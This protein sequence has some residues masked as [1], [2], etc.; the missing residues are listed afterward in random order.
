M[1]GILNLFSEPAR[2]LEATLAALDK[3]EPI[4]LGNPRWSESALDEALRLVPVGCQVLG[5]TAQPRGLAP[6]DWPRAWSA[7]IMI[8]TGGTGGRVK[9]AIHHRSTLA[10]AVRSL[11]AELAT[12][13][14]VGPLHGAVLTPPWHVSGLMPAIRARETGGTFWVGDGRFRAEESLPAVNLPTGGVRL[15]SLVPTQLTRLLARPEGEAWLRQFDLVLLG[16]AAVPTELIESIRTRRLPIALTYGMTETAAAIALAWPSEK[17]GPI[18]GCALPGV[19]LEARAG[20]L[21]VDTPSL[22]R[23]HWPAA[24]ASRPM[25]TGDLGEVDSDGGVV[26]TGRAD[27]LVITGGEKVDPSR[28]EQVLTAPGLARAAWVLGL[29]DATWGRLLV[30]VVVAPPSAEQKLREAAERELEP[31]ARPRRYLFVDALP[32]D[33]RGKLDH[34]AVTRGL[35]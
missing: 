11:A 5:A 8:P 22:C 23:G 26:V 31:A 18:R 21:W 16:G 29:P 9:F 24:P 13:G 3:A 12:R 34:T 27:R 28:V 14:L 4:F 7:H 2:H 25:D 19:H 1:N 32:Y 30:A 6:C 20:R 15:A 35:A 17:D 33:E 10:A